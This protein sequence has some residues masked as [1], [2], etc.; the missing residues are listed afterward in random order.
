MTSRLPRPTARIRW[1]LPVT[2]AVLPAAICAVL[3][4]RIGLPGGH[5]LAAASQPTADARTAS[6]T[7]AGPSRAVDPTDPAGILAALDR[8]R[9]QAYASRQPAL[10]AGVYRS[11]S[12]LAQDTA[13]LTSTVPTGCQLVGLHTSYQQLSVVATDNR[14]QLQVTATVT[15][16]AL[17]CNGTLLRRTPAA[18]PV[19]LAI[20]LTNAGGGFLV[21]GESRAG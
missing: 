6:P 10:L 20:L 15:G 19:R 8:R 4:G 5:Q 12:L 17:T 11:P 2:L 3:I 9:S 16:G 1:W 14:L 13:Q 18:P 21:A 7:A